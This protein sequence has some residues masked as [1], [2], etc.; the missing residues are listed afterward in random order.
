MKKT[1]TLVILAIIAVT[2]LHA[3]NTYPV[4]KNRQQYI[5]AASSKC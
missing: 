3:Q 1:L 2:T 5:T 4:K